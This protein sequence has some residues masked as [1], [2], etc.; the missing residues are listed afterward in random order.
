MSH[1]TYNPS[2][3]RRNLGRSPPAF[4]FPAVP[5]LTPPATRALAGVALLSLG[6]LGAFS[7]LPGPAPACDCI[8]VTLSHSDASA[9]LRL[10]DWGHEDMRDELVYLTHDDEEP[11]S[12]FAADSTVR[13]ITEAVRLALSE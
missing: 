13:S 2:A 9:L 7:L 4:R 1:P 12:V 3:L 6:S 8:T 11:L 10:L 5:R